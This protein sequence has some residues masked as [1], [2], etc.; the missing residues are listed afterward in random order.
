MDKVW[1]KLRKY[2]RPDPKDKMIGVWNE[3]C[4]RELGDVEEEAR[5]TEVKIHYG[6]IAEVGTQK[7]S[8]NPG[9]HIATI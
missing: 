6:R 9:G 7:S 5:R 3:D 4:F 1:N 2:K 8:G